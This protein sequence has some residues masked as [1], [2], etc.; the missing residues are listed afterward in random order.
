MS[1]EGI[2]D[3]ENLGCNL[4]GCWGLVEQG[5]YNSTRIFYIPIW[6]LECG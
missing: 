3:S 5:F 1:A 2:C 4:E 6:F